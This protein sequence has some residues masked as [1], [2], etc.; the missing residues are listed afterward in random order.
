MK[1]QT[2]FA[3][4]ITSSSLLV[5]NL[6]YADDSDSLEAHSS[7]DHHVAAPA[8]ALE[9]GIATGYTQGVGPIGGNSQH[10]EDVARAGGAA[11]LDAMYR[12]N[13][14]FA[15][16]AY[17][18]FSKYATGDALNSHADVLGASAGIQAAA[19]LRP[20]RSV[21]PWASIG[22][23]WRGLW[24]SP[25]TGKNTALQGLELAR[26]Q[27]GVD[28]RV[29]ED[30]SISPVVGGSLNMYLSEDSPMTTKYTEISD[31]KVNFMGFAG[32][33]G[34]FVIGGKR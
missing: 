31:K 7:F 16:G 15:V 6:A 23:G 22:A 11:E 33:A 4:V 28:Y 9:I 27:I 19:H 34:R 26:L 12:I 1:N 3:L 30:V 14:M 32:L 29:S 24:L 10:V 5:G 2:L 20:E 25:D 8:N 18:S 13:P 21:D 17:G